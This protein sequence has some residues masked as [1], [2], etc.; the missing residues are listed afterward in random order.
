MSGDPA[1]RN[2]ELHEVC[3]NVEFNRTGVDMRI[4]GIDTATGLI[5]DVPMEQKK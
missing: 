5:K 3:L 2:H 4:A 1:G